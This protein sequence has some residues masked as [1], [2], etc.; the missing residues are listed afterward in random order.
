MPRPAELTASAVRVENALLAHDYLHKIAALEAPRQ[1]ERDYAVPKGMKLRDEIGRYWRIARAYWAD[2][3]KEQG[4]ADERTTR[5]KWL[6]PLLRE[7]L[8]FDHVMVGDRLLENWAMP[9]NLC[10]VARWHHDPDGAPAPDR[11]IDLVHVAD[12]LCLMSGIGTGIDGLRYQP[13]RGARSRPGLKVGH[14]AYLPPRA[15]A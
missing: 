5:N 1:S 14:Q 8:G 2:F 4:S 7:V 10:A 3:A 9:G 13:S 11:L 6:L 12:M 15:T